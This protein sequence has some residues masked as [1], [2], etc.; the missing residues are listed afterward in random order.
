MSVEDE[1]E[2]LLADPVEEAGGDLVKQLRAALKKATAEN[3]T[4]KTQVAETAQV[5]RASSLKS[6]LEAHGAKPALAKYF[7]ADGTV[8]ETAVLAWLKED[9]ELFGWTAPEAVET[10]QAEEVAA[11]R[12]VSALVPQNAPDLRARAAALSSKPTPALGRNISPADAKEAQQ[13]A[14][15]LLAQLNTSLR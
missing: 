5:T 1:F 8:D 3:K 6:A 15:S 13:I 14:D 9:G 12:A 2:A 10:V 4:L 7:P 11:I